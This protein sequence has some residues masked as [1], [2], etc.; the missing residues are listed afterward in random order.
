[1][2][3]SSAEILPCPVL[4]RQLFQ[5]NYGAQE[6]V[7]LI[8]VVKPEGE[9]R[10]KMQTASIAAAT[11]TTLNWYTTPSAGRKPITIRLETNGSAQTAD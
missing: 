5:P 9:R 11:S 6:R 10:F 2:G 1:M 7:T 3:A 8:P 4:Q